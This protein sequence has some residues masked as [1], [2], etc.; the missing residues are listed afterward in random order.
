VT[1]SVIAGHPMDMQR[2][3]GDIRTPEL[4]HPCSH[5]SSPLFAKHFTLCE[6][7]GADF[8]TQSG[9]GHK[10]FPDQHMDKCSQHSPTG[11]ISCTHDES[12]PWIR[13]VV[14]RGWWRPL[15]KRGL[16]RFFVLRHCLR[17]LPGS[18][19]DSLLNSS[20]HSFSSPR[21]H[22]GPQLNKAARQ[23]S[24]HSTRLFCLCAG[25][26]GLPLERVVTRRWLPS[27]PFRFHRAAQRFLDGSR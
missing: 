24:T 25:T 8:I 3:R 26:A 2:L 14:D 7:N 1:H 15:F 13:R 18:E 10:A 22:P 4:L 21:H 17:S 9:L 20:Q 12:A 11:R 27:C 5:V 6:I 23:K 19:P 16:R